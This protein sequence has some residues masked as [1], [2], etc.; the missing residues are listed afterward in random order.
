MKIVRIETN[1]VNFTAFHLAKQW[2]CTAWKLLDQVRRW[3]APCS[4]MGFKITLSLGTDVPFNSVNCVTFSNC[5]GLRSILLLCGVRGTSEKQTD[6]CLFVFHSCLVAEVVTLSAALPWGCC[7]V[8]KYN[9][10]LRVQQGHLAIISSL[11]L[12]IS[13]DSLVAISVKQLVSN[14]AFFLLFFLLLPAVTHS[15][16]SVFPFWGCLCPSKAWFSRHTLQPE[17][18]RR[19]GVGVHSTRKDPP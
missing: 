1:V 12:P 19:G 18:P 9:S 5:R 6:F 10:L 16:A 17:P 13:A 8:S 3:H 7:E 15:Q 2:Q 14:A 4:S 11:M